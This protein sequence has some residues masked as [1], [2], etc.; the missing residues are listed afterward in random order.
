MRDSSLFIAVAIAFA[1]IAHPRTYQ[2]VHKLFKKVGAPN[3]VSQNGVATT[4]GLLA[5]ALVAAV[6][7]CLIL[8]LV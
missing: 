5:H 3:V 2:I 6:I 7:A 1:L 8:Q 4:T